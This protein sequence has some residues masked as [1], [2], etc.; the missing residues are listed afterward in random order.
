MVAPLVPG[1]E[2]SGWVVDGLA[3]VELAG[4][5]VVDLGG[6]LGQLLV[7]HGPGRL[8]GSALALV[9]PAPLLRRIE[10]E[11]EHL[12]SRAAVCCC[13]AE[14][15]ALVAPPEAVV[16]HDV[17]AELEGAQPDL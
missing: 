14:S 15:G 16:D 12:D 3:A 1:R 7:G 4:R 5:G 2:P 9:Q 10:L 6:P 17:D 13:L 11:E 8:R